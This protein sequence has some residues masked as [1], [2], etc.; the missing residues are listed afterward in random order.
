MTQSLA[1]YVVVGR[2]RGF[3]IEHCVAVALKRAR[4]SIGVAHVHTQINNDGK[5][6]VGEIEFGRE[7]IAALGGGDVEIYQMGIAILY[8][9][10]QTRSTIIAPATTD[11]QSRAVGYRREQIIVFG[12]FCRF[13]GQILS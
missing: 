11:K 2:F 6:R 12:K 3:S 9:M 13:C 7:I 1:R 4:Y 5:F 8:G 10:S